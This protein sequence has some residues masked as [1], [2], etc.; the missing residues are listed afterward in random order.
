[1]TALELAAEVT[2]EGPPLVILHGLFGSA[3]NWGLI[4]KRLSDIRRVHGLDLRNHGASPWSDD[5][6]YP[7]MAGDVAAT[8]ERQGIGPCDVLGHSMGGKT[9]MAL[10]LA[11]PD[12]VRRLIV[13][14][15]APVTYQREAYPSYV[16]AMQ[17]ADLTTATRRSEVEA[18]LAAAV[19]EAELRAFLVQNL[20]RDGGHFRWR[21]NLSGISANLD[22]VTAWPTIAGRFNGPTTFLA[23]ER[24]NYIRPR[25][26]AAVK[27]LFPAATL[28]EVGG[29]GHW[30]HAEQPERFLTLVRRVLA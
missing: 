9:A 23:G 30:A 13:V 20:V 2:G 10:A 16:E 29:A 6:S 24:S 22:T 28:I 25:D 14:D 19:P 18:Q 15:I 26:E 8:I 5:M 11:R 21:I 27:A 1:M 4:A 12:L 7:A 3:R 17:K